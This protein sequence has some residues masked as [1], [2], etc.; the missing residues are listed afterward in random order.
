M[1]NWRRSEAYDETGLKWIPPSPNLRTVDAAFL[2][3]GVEILQAGGVSVG[4]GTDT[5]FEVLGAPWIHADALSTVLSRRQIPGVSFSPA[6]FT[7]REGPFVGE[8]CQ[9]VRIAITDRTALRSM[10]MGL[11]IADALH[12]MYP[13]SFALDKIVTLLGSQFTVDRLKRG[14][15]PADIIAGWSEDL[16]KFRA[17]RAKYLL[18]E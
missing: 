14:D 11:E 10:R 6:Q 12:R 15:A 4:R 17:M 1:E 18:Y 8:V 9:G 5:P 16:A 3:P 13:D 7:P 2:Y